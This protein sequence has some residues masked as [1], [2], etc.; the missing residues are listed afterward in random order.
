MVDAGDARN[1][2]NYPSEAKR[3]GIEGWALVNATL[4]AEGHVT[5]VQIVELYPADTSY[6]FAES[7]IGVAKGVRFANPKR[8]PTQVQFRVKF[9]LTDKHSGDPPRLDSPRP[10]GG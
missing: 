1:P 3:Q 9:A 8:Q 4:D 6:G 10:A 2:A 5:Y 7:A